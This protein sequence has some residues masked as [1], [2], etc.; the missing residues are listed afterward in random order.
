MMVKVEQ[1]QLASA[2]RVVESSLSNNKLCSAKS[3]VVSNDDLL[4][5]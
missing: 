2:S 4:I 1:V 5:G 3:E